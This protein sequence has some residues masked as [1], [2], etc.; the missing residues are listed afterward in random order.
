[1]LMEDRQLV[2]DMMADYSM[3]ID[4]LLY[5]APSGEEG[6]EFSHIGGEYEAFK[7][8]AEQI[9]DIGGY[10]YVDH[11]TQQDCT[12]NQ[13]DHWDLQFDLLVDAYLDYHSHD[14]GD[15]MPTFEDPEPPLHYPPSV[16]LTNIELIDMSSTYNI[17]FYFNMP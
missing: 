13:T 3:D 4:T 16:S 1:M 6:I 5:T 7:G 17:I 14:S 11:C 2:E 10:C 12:E 8:L 15:G 9:A